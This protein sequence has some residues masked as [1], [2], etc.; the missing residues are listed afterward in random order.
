MAKPFS[1]IDRIEVRHALLASGRSLFAAG[2]LKGVS[3]SRLAE[4]AGISKAS[5]YAFFPSKEALVLDVL[6]AEAPGVSAR[7][8]AHLADSG[9]PAREALTRFLTATMQ[10]YATNE[11]LARLVSEPQSMAA[12]AQRVRPEDIEAKAAWMERPLVTFFNQRIARGE[13]PVRPIETL[14]DLMRSVLLLSLH[15]GRFEPEPRFGAMSTDLISLV[16]AGLTGRED[17]S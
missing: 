4:A 13:M 17:Q 14:L 12:I 2:G 10:E 3:L 8:T 16:A 5:F 7:T 9:L 1:D 6:A 15:R 11:V